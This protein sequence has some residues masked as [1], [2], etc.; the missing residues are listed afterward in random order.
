MHGAA[1]TIS[2]RAVGWW[3][4]YNAAPRACPPGARVSIREI[5]PRCKIYTR[6]DTSSAEHGSILRL[7]GAQTPIARATAI[8]LRAP[9]W[10]AGFNSARTLR[11]REIGGLPG[12]WRNFGRKSTQIFRNPPKSGKMV[13][14]TTTQKRK[15]GKAAKS[16]GRARKS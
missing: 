8:S 3:A 11:T 6:I 15:I 12:K 5:S 4:T 16:A 2:V 14:P 7:N 13:K 9:K 1:H 10:R